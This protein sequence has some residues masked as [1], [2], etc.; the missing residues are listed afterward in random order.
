MSE[1]YKDEVISKWG[2]SEEF[3]EFTHKNNIDFLN[4]SNFF[5]E[6]FKEI[7]LLKH[8][9]PKDELVQRKIYEIHMFINEKLYTCSKQVFHSLGQIYVSDA[10][11]KNNIDNV[12]GEGTAEFVKRAIDV[13]CN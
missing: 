11:F 3:N 10:R 1:K 4:I 13:Y 2:E 6:I 9:D 8:N 5:M 7:G 12:G